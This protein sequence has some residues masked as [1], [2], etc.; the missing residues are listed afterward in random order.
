MSKPIIVLAGSTGDLGG[1]IGRAL[2][3]EAV[4]A[5]GEVRKLV[6]H[7]FED[8]DRLRR[9]CE[10]ASCVVSALS[11]L[12][13]V[14]VKLQGR[15]LD[16][17]VAAS[18]PRFIPS[19]FA[20]DFTKV[21]P[22]Q[23]RNFDL[24][25]EFKAQIDQRGISATSILNGAFADM[26]TGQ[27]PIVLFK[28]RR[29]LYWENPDQKMDFTTKDDVAVFTAKAA[30]DDTTPRH[31]KIAGDEVSARDLAAM[32]T[33]LTGKR[34]RLLRGG[35]LG[36]LEKLTWV[37]RKV[38][39]QPDEVFPPWQGM[40]YTHN[41]FSGIAKMVDLDNT[42]YEGIAWTKVRDVLRRAV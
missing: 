11:G 18:V 9:A 2:D 8:D 24:R 31:L 6:R 38:A 39:P 17:A 13:D 15:L 1:R 25:R 33:D 41:L 30:F 4:K 34:F 12:R 7:D 37:A 29:I 28:L 23:N 22:G 16:A 27:A 40:Q 32:M 36:R 14:I 19:D 3:R 21:P 26:L 20:V 10:G 5:D 35:S 42:R